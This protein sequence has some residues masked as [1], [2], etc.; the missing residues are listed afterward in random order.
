M[1]LRS[2][3]ATLPAIAGP[4]RC[5]VTVSFHRTVPVA[6]QQPRP[7]PDHDK[8]SRTTADQSHTLPQG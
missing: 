2:D 4:A 1:T 7:C 3:L 6:C 5:R 8:E